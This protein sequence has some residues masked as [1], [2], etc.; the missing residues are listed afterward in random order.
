MNLLSIFKAIFL[1]FIEGLTEFIPVSSTA[2]LLLSSWL[3]DFSEIE[4]GA[5]EVIIQLG[6]ILA[7]IFLYRAKIF[8]IL[9]DFMQC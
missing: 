5:F 2:H 1:G 8:K 6:A 7:V 4:N 9:K 3:I